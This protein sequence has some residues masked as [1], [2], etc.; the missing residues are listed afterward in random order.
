MLSHKGTDRDTQRQGQA[1]RGDAR[2]KGK[3]EEHSQRSAS[4][5]TTLEVRWLLGRKK[6]K[7]NAPLPPVRE[8]DPEKALSRRS[9][10][11]FLDKKKIKFRNILLSCHLTD[12]THG[13]AHLPHSHATPSPAVATEDCGQLPEGDIFPFHL[14]PFIN[15]L[16]DISI[17][18]YTLH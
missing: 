1:Q 4:G 17:Y 5:S 8:L 6:V 16:V 14:R 11:N 13:C 7:P 18:L 9:F 10:R 12:G 15:M 2:H 3:A